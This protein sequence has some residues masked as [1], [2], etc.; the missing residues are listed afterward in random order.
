M[1]EIQFLTSAINGQTEKTVQLSAPKWE[2]ETQV[3]KFFSDKDGVYISSSI[4]EKYGD[5]PN[6]F[7]LQLT[8]NQFKSLSNKLDKLLSVTGKLEKI[9]K[10]LLELRNEIG[11]PV[12]VIPE[13]FADGTF[14]A[15]YDKQ[16][17]EP[18]FK[19]C[20]PDLKACLDDYYSFLNRR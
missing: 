11:A 1:T 15:V 5:E 4:I 20:A 16:G 19:K 10:L 3:L 2:D 18:I 7:G 8:E 12:V 6:Y 14:L 9:E 17:E 13:Y